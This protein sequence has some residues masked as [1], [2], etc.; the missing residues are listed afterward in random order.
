MLDTATRTAIEAALDRRDIDRAVALADAALVAGAR[1]PLLCNLIA[2][3]AEEAG[4][5]AAAHRA[6]GEAMALSPADAPG[7]GV[8]TPSSSRR[9][10]RSSRRRSSA[11]V[12]QSSRQ[13]AL[14][15]AAR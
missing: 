13:F 4:D 12:M 14:A 3:R 10:G 15:A 5:F 11:S 2:W 9:C 1:D 6:L 7:T 8:A